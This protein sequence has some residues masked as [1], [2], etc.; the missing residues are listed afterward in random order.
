MEIKNEVMKE[1]QDAQG[2]KGALLVI[3]SALESGEYPPTFF[4][5][6]DEWIVEMM[7]EIAELLRDRYGVKVPD[8]EV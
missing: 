1:L 6:H 4:I 8:S 7:S 3:L 2:L 5:F